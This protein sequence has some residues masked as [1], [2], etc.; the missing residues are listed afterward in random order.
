MNQ[1]DPVQQAISP[2]N[3]ITDQSRDE[4][5][6]NSSR[7][8]DR[9]RPANN[10]QN[11]QLIQNTTTRAPAPRSAG[12]EVKQGGGKVQN[13]DPTKGQPVQSPT[14]AI[15]TGQ[16]PRSNAQGQGGLHQ[17][18][19]K[20]SDQQSQQNQQHQ[21]DQRPTN[22]LP[23]SRQINSNQKVQSNSRAQPQQSQ[24]P[25]GPPTRPNHHR[26]DQDQPHRQDDVFDGPQLLDSNQGHGQSQGQSRSRGRG[27]GQQRSSP[28]PYRQE[29]ANT[30]QLGHRRGQEES[31]RGH[32]GHQDMNM[33]EDRNQ[34]RDQHKVQSHDY[35]HQEDPTPKSGKGKR[36]RTREDAP[37]PTRSVSK[38]Q[39][40][41][42]D[43]GNG[44]SEIEM[45]V[46][47]EGEEEDASP[48]DA[49]AEVSCY[50]L[51]IWAE[52]SV[53]R[54]IRSCQGTPRTME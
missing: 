16:A 44:S 46:E 32:G 30:E 7:D 52:L 53:D 38:R 19:P 50:G 24:R 2:H 10:A 28:S 36:S 12:Q 26:N 34:G 5:Q 42:L 21:G 35:A 54:K 45:E 9:V 48:F 20:Q 43:V 3:S 23:P 49:F 14:L 51:W 18:S 22:N 6:I 29:D 4:Q 11:V 47:K 25:V 39:K 8:E 15:S 27:Q 13:V 37:D 31:N 17:P 33:D 40:Q 1:A 41:N